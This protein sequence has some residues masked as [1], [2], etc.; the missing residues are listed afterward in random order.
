MN[1]TSLALDVVIRSMFSYMEASSQSRL[2]RG[3]CLL[4]ALKFS[5]NLPLEFPDAVLSW[6]RYAR[7]SV[8]CAGHE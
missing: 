7:R 4:W 2:L 5:K 3:Q 6:S 1:E 8:T